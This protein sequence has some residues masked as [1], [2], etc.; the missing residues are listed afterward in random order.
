MTT[1]SPAEAARVVPT[2]AAAA[3]KVLRISRLS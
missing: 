3:M 1:A 2:I